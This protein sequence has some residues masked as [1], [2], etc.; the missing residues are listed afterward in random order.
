MPSAKESQMDAGL[1]YVCVWNSSFLASN[2]FD[3]AR[4]A[5]ATKTKPVLQ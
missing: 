3:A 2:D 4:H 1:N 5:F